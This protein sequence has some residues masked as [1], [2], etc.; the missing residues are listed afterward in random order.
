[1]KKNDSNGNGVTPPWWRESVMAYYVMSLINCIWYSDNISIIL[2]ILCIN[3]KK[4]LRF[5][6]I[7][8]DTVSI[9]LITARYGLRLLKETS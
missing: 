8:I 5:C 6:V 7:Y 1:M 4:T 9:K 3:L 2:L